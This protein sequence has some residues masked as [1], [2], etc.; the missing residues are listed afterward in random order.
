M[1]KKTTLPA[2]SAILSNYRG[3]EAT[4]KRVEEQIRERWG[5]SAAKTYDPFR[6]C[7]TFHAWISAG[8][9]VKKGEKALRS[10]TFVE[11]KGA[12]GEITQKYPKNVF[13]F[14]VTQVEPLKATSVIPEPKTV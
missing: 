2:S 11:K 12:K 3:S 8:F 7:L 13:L 10:V 5:D 14:F 6:N 4:R 1:P 9:R